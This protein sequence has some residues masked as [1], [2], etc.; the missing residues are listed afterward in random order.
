MPGFVMVS[1]SLQLYDAS[2]CLDS[3]AFNPHENLL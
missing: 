2:A 1:S 3:E